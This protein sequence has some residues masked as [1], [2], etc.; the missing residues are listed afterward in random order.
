[1]QQSTG[2]DNL[3]SAKIKISKMLC[4]L[5]LFCHVI[6][7]QRSEDSTDMNAGNPEHGYNQNRTAPA[8]NDGKRWK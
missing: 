6:D 1:M 2:D 7:E 8:I 5:F 4:R 3:C